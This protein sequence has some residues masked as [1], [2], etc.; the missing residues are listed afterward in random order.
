LSQKYGECTSYGGLLNWHLDE[1]KKIPNI[2]EKFPAG[3]KNEWDFIQETVRIAKN[4][5]DFD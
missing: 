1:L 4:K 3:L 2:E 5:E